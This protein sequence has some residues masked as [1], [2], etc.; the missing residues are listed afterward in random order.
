MW[1]LRTLRCSLIL[2]PRSGGLLRF[3]I[4]ESFFEPRDRL[5]IVSHDFAGLR[6]SR[7]L[8]DPVL[9]SLDPIPQQRDGIPI[10]LFNFAFARL[11]L[12]QLRMQL[13]PSYFQ[14]PRRCGNGVIDGAPDVIA[15]E[16]D[17]HSEC[18]ECDGKFL[19][20]PVQRFRSKR[21]LAGLELGIDEQDWGVPTPS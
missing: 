16:S 8:L 5:A 9:V 1:R 14:W 18:Y 2:S 21:T 10:L 12:L 11:R 17:E 20:G 3:Q 13:L 4:A 15:D 19:H 7:E 6:I